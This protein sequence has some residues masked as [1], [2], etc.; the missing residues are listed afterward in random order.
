MDPCSAF[1]MLTKQPKC[2]CL[3]SGKGMAPLCQ[4]LWSECSSS[5]L[6]F[7]VQLEKAEVCQYNVQTQAMSAGLMQ[8]SMTVEMW[9]AIEHDLMPN[10][11]WL[12]IFM[13]L[14]EAHPMVLMSESKMSWEA[15][16]EAPFQAIK[17]LH[18]QMRA[19]MKEEAEASHCKKEANDK[20]DS[21]GGG[22]S[23]QQ[24]QSLGNTNSNSN[25]GGSSG[26]Q[27]QSSGNTKW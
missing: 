8:S 27:Q 9:Q 6:E 24:Q 21:N 13:H 1:I 10:M 14:V 11:S 4:S 12:K 15:A 2:I 3:S 20:G 5:G 17:Y 19:Q 7:M 16:K 22:N 18:S 25:G 26:Q 23:R